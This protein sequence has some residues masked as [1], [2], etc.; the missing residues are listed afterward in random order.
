[1]SKLIFFLL[2]CSFV[3]TSNEL[4]YLEKINS[5]HFDKKF[6]NLNLGLKLH[7]DIIKLKEN[8]WR[9]DNYFQYQGGLSWKNIY[10]VPG[11]LSNVDTNLKVQ[12]QKQFQFVNSKY[13]SAK[14]IRKLYS[15]SGYQKVMDSASENVGYEDKNYFSVRRI[16]EKISQLWPYFNSK[17]QEFFQLLSIAKMPF[18]LPTSHQKFYAMKKGESYSLNHEGIFNFGASLDWEVDFGVVDLLKLSAFNYS[19]R[20]KG[21]YLISLFK[22]DDRYLVVSVTD[23]KN[24][25][26]R[27]GVLEPQNFNGLLSFN[28]IYSYLIPFSFASHNIQSEDISVVYKLDMSVYSLQ[29]SLNKVYMGSIKELDDLS[30]KEFSGVKKLKSKGKLKINT[31]TQ[32]K[33][34]IAFVIKFKQTLRKYYLS[35]FETSPSG[36]LT[37]KTT[38]GIINDFEHCLFMV[39]CKKLYQHASIVFDDTKQK[40]GLTYKYSLKDSNTFGHELKS[41]LKHI[42]FITGEFEY[43]KTKN[44]KKFKNHGA[45]TFNVTAKLSSDDINDWLN[46]GTGE[47][48]PIISTSFGHSLNAWKTSYRREWYMKNNLRNFL[49]NGLSF[50]LDI[51]FPK[52]PDLIQA[53]KFV[54]IYQQ[55]RNQVDYKKQAGL[56]LKLF[57]NRKFNPSA[58]RYITNGGFY[59]PVL[60]NKNFDF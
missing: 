22:R 33:Y 19:F 29:K 25:R 12:Y 60:E 11:D 7:R 40:W 57:D 43:W 31:K 1:L 59:K 53:Q 13:Y 28:D 18:N 35:I 37:E 15:L 41:Y 6:K 45:T 34:N 52:G 30:K 46:K 50:I 36:E 20:L 10:S 23:N 4:Q 16:K 26:D 39:D 3:A 27:T 2:L 21:N 32:K 54:D 42:N 56:L 44:F 55:S 14:T 38:A 8:L 9:V 51:H 49:F 58:F 17:K 5:F 48:W 47:Y 24:K